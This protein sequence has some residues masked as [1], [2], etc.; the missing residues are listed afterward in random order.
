M[1]YR[2]LT[3]EDVEHFIEYGW[4]MLK[5]AFAR[6]DALA[7]QDYLWNKVEERGVLRNDPST[8][9]QPMVQINENYTD[10]P[11]PRCNSKRLGDAIEDLIGHGRWANRTVYGETDT[12]SGFGWWPVNFS[13]DADKPWTVP[14]GGWHWD[15][16]HFRHYIDSPEQGLLCLCLFSDIRH[17]GG[18][19]FV[20]EGS[21][22]VVAKFL[23]RY[24]EGLELNEAIGMLNREHP[25]LADLTGANKER[26]ELCMPP[27]EAARYRID[28]FMNRV[29]VDENGFRLRVI[30]TTGE[31]GDAILCH[32]FLYHSAS[33]NKL[34]VPRFMCNRT[35]PLREKLEL[36]RESPDEHSPLER[37][38]R[39]ALGYEAASLA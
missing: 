10:G 20:A 29:T 15:G 19:T 35:T 38:I 33:Q 7:A 24:P 18:G 21:H 36:R 9:T 13:R 8:W 3:A 22:K 6:E 14:V 27:E 17:Q 34:R 25:W 12:L 2:V 4:V 31:P 11:F 1:N 39:L 32:P 26:E 28:K 5:E 23:E 16:I 30:E 37:S